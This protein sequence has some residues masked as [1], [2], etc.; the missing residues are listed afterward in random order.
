MK[1]KRER[2]VL[3]GIQQEN[4]S[5]DRNEA[6]NTDGMVI[7]VSTKENA[8]KKAIG[9]KFAIPLNFDFFKCRA[10]PYGLK[11]DL[12]V[13]LEFD[14]SEKII[15]FSEDVAVTYRLPDIRQYLVK[16]V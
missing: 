11:E 7:T 10:C 6:K 13:R 14:S 1:K 12:T 8:I 4:G 5:K 3:Q 15:L 2:E 16:V 9:K